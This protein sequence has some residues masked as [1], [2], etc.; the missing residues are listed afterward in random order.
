MLKIVKFLSFQMDLIRKKCI[1]QGK[2]HMLA[3]MSLNG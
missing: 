2:D 1:Y 3:I